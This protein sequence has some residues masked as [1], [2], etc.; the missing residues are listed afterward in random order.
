M[1]VLLILLNVRFIATPR[2]TPW[3]NC[4]GG[5]CNCNREMWRQHRRLWSWIV[6]WLNSVGLGVFLT[7]LKVTSYIERYWN[8]WSWMCLTTWVLKCSWFAVFC[9]GSANL[10]VDVLRFQPFLSFPFIGHL[11]CFSS[12]GFA[13]QFFNLLHEKRN[14]QTQNLMPSHEAIKRQNFLP[15]LQ[16]PSGRAEGWTTQRAADWIRSNDFC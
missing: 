7:P 8:T 15:E 1:I 4:S 14:L 5:G 11:S 12:W 13:S 2:F 16:W 9:S 6:R 3:N 10:A